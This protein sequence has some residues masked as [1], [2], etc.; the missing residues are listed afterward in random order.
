MKDIINH[1]SNVFV[2]VKT[3]MGKKLFYILCMGLLTGFLLVSFSCKVKVEPIDKVEKV[4]KKTGGDVIDSEKYSKADMDF[5]ETK[6]VDPI[7]ETEIIPYFIEGAVDIT[8]LLESAAADPLGTTEEYAHTE[9]KENTNYNFIVK[10]TG[11]IIS[12][13]NV[14]KGSVNVDLPPYDNI[15]DIRIFTGPILSSTLNSIRDAYDDLSYG[16]YINQM[17]WGRIG[18]RIKAI[19]KETVL[20]DLDRENLVDKPVSFYGAFTLG[21]PD[22]Y[23][24]IEITPVKLEIGGSE[25]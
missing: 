25:L 12:V 14:S 2:T 1:I 16:D 9:T 5:D 21:E 6:I 23:S 3:G 22:D 18:N 15:A 4:D 19:V 8:V 11:R 10:G 20:N 7:W 17:Q 13:N 24:K